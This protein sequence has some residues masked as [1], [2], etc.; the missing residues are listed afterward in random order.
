MFQSFLL[1]LCFP[2]NRTSLELKRHVV[3]LYGQSYKLL[4]EPFGIETAPCH[5]QA[6]T[7][8]PF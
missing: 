5:L 2:S 8:I 7:H 3:T 4:I 6:N 1:F